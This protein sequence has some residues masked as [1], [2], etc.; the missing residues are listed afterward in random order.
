MKL[1]MAGGLAL[2]VALTTSCGPS[3]AKP[4][5]AKPAAHASANPVIGQWTIVDPAC[6]S[7]QK[8]VY[9]PNE[10]AGF[11]NPDGIYPGWRKVPV[12]YNVSATEVWVLVQGYAS[13][14]TR[15]FVIDA[16]H[17]KPDDGDGCIYQRDGS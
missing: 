8:I 5:K 4:H 13:N 17:I 16:N 6:E 7:V 14:E 11:E 3:D 15:V 9:S 10:W 2:M 12:T 1:V